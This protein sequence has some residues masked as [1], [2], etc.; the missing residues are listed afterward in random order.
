MFGVFFFYILHKVGTFII[1]NTDWLSQEF[2]TIVSKYYYIFF[3]F[4]HTCLIIKIVESFGG[5]L[6]HI[7]MKKYKSH[8]KILPSQTMRQK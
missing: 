7:D 4:F 6:D 5:K 2:H 8:T 1:N 3:F